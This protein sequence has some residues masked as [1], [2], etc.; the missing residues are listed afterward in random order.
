[1]WCNRAGQEGWLRNIPDDPHNRA[2]ITPISWLG[3]E[4]VEKIPF[5]AVTSPLA[6][7]VRNRKKKI[8]DKRV[9]S[10]R[11]KSTI[12]SNTTDILRVILICVQFLIKDA[13]AR[14]HVCNM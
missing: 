7:P 10:P 6:V 2:R 3:G 1:M 8:F 11:V 13:R 9:S 4:I 14:A 12:D 5:H